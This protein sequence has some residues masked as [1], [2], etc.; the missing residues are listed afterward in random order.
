MNSASKEI[1]LTWIRSWDKNGRSL[2]TKKQRY[3][4]FTRGSTWISWW[5]VNCIKTKRKWSW[6]C[7]EMIWPKAV[8]IIQNSCTGACF[9]ERRVSQMKNN[10]VREKGSR[11]EAQNTKRW[12]AW[13]E[14]VQIKEMLLIKKWE[15]GIKQTSRVEKICWDRFSTIVTANG[16]LA[17]NLL[18]RFCSINERI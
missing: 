3:L 18:A 13:V 4:R 16:N 14:Y 11:R 9:K 17:G 5:P 15:I 12:F 10:F 6:D 1:F 8:C 7:I 2:N